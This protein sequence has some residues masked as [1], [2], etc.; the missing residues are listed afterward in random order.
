MKPKRSLLQSPRAL[1]LRDLLALCVVAIAP[2]AVG[3]AGA[4]DGSQRPLGSRSADNVWH[5]AGN[6]G[7]TAD[8]GTRGLPNAY[9]TVRLDRDALQESLARVSKRR[10]NA[11]LPVLTLPM[12]DGSFAR[13]RIDAAPE[14][15]REAVQA[16][17]GRGLD[18]GDARIE[19]TAKGLHAIVLTPRGS[20]Y[21]DPV[22]GVAGDYVTYFAKDAGRPLLDAPDLPLAAV[23]QIE[24]VMGEKASRSPVQRKIDSR[25]LDARQMMQGNEV[26]PGVTYD[27]LPVELEAVDATVERPAEHV[28]PDDGDGAK[29][30]LVDIKAD[31]TPA[32]LARIEEL[33]GEVVNSVRKYRAIRA[34]LPLDTVEVLATL[35]EVQ[36]IRVADRAITNQEVLRPKL[37]S[38]AA[39]T[40]TEKVDTS[41]GDVAHDAAGA[42]AT[43]GVDGTGIGIGV[44]SDGIGTLA[45][46]QA[47]GDLPDSVVILA[48]HAG[49]DGDREGTAM[50]EIVHDLAPGAHLYFA[51]AL[52]G[53]AQFAAN[54]EALCEAG[55]DIIVDDIFYVSEAAFQDD[56]VARG[57]NAAVEA[58]CFY[59]SS[60][61]NGGNLNDGTAGVWEGDFADAGGDLNINGESV[62]DLH[63]F[64]EGVSTNPI[65]DAADFYL[66]KWAD[67]LGASAN[68][69]DLYLV[70]ESLIGLVG[71][72]TDIQDGEHDPL[73]GL[74]GSG[75]SGSDEDVGRHLVVVRHAGEG[76][77]LRLNALRGQLEHATAGQTVGH[78]AGEN[79]IGVAAVDARSAGGDD[80]V[81]DGTESVETFS[82]DGPRRI[83][84]QPDGTPITPED[85]S[86]TGGEVLDKPDIAAADGVSTSTPGFGTFHGTSAAAPHAAAIAALMVEAAGGRNQID[87]PTLRDALAEAALDIEAEG[88]DRDSGAGIPL[89]PAAVS[90]VESDQEHRA[91]NSTLQDQTLNV[92]ADDLELDLSTLFD[93]PD[94]D[95]L[96]YTVLSGIEGI[97]VVTLSGS[98]LTID[99]LAPGTVTVAIRATDAGGLSVV[100]TISVTVERDYGATD[101]DTDDDGLIEI[102]TLEQ[103]NA[104]RYDLDGNGE[105]EV[106]ADW[107][108]YFEA[109]DDAQEEMGCAGGCAGFELMADLDFDEPGSYASGAVDRGWSRAELGAGWE[110]IGIRVNRSSPEGAFVATFD[111]N[112][113]T[114]ANL[115]INRPERDHVGMFGYANNGPVMNVGLTDVNITGNNRVGGLVG[116]LDNWLVGNSGERGIRAS[117]ATGRVSGR[118][119]VGGLIGS[120]SVSIRHCYAAVPVSGD[121]SVGG[122][123]GR[124][125]SDVVHSSFAT[126]A[127]SGK[128]GVG[129]LVGVSWDPIVA[130]YATGAVSGEGSRTSFYC[131]EEGGV[132][133]LLGHACGSWVVASY[134]TGRVS[135]ARAAGGL[136][137]SK[138]GGPT[139]RSSY[140]DIET[141]GLVVGVGDDDANDNG[142][143][144]GGETR[145][146]GVGGMTTAALQRPKGYE[147]IYGEWQGTLDDLPPHDD[148]HFGTSLQYPALKADRNGDGVATW[149]EFGTQVRDR[150]ELTI[151][152]AGGQASLSWTAVT[153]DHWT[154]PLDLTYAVYRDDAVIA[155]GVAADSYT[156]T[157]PGEGAESTV[158]Q[159]VAMVD[160]GEASRSNLVT[161]RNRPPAPPL[162]S[163]QPAR[164]GASFSYTFGGASDPDGDAVTHRATGLPG[165]LT[166]TASTRTFSGSPEAGDVGAT[167][168]TV[169]ATDDGTPV[170]SSTAT[171][172]LTVIALNA[173]NRAP[174]PVGSLDAVSLSTGATSTV[175]VGRA[176]E[177][178]D[179]DVLG[180]QA[181]TS[182]GDVTAAHISADAV[183]LTGIGV[184]EAT[185]TV[186]ATDGALTA[187]QSFAV[188]VVNAEPQAVASLADRGLLI[189]DDPVVLA[190]SEA[191]Y[192]ADSDPLTY[193]ASTSDE[194]VA[195]ASVS[196]AT[197]TLTPIAV[198]SATVTVTATDAGGSNSTATQTFEVTIR[199]DYDID[200]DGL[201]EI[202][203]LGQLDAV[204]FDRDGDGVVDP[205]IGYFTTDPL[206]H[207]VA[208]YRTAYPDA[209]A[210]MGCESVNSCTGYELVADLDF[211]TN[212]SG[213]AD[214]GDTFWNDGRGWKPIG[215]P[216]VLLRIGAYFNS[217]PYAATFD[218]N[219]HVI[220]NLFIDRPDEWFIGL[221]GF[222]H[223][224]DLNRAVIRN[225]G[226][227]DVDVTGWRVTG[228]LVGR[229]SSL[230]EAS[231]ATGRAEAV[232]STSEKRSAAG[233]LV[234]QNGWSAGSR[235]VIR[236]SFAAVAV[237]ADASAVG[238]LVGFNGRLSQVHASFAT[239]SVESNNRSGG[240]VGINDGEVSTSYATGRSTVEFGR[241]G[242]LTA[243]NQGVII[244]SFATGRPT[245]TLPDGETRFKP[246]RLGG[247]AGYST[248]EIVGSYWDTRTSGWRVG[249][250]GDDWPDRNGRVDGN[251]TATPGVLGKT[252]AALQAPE[253]YHGIYGNWNA[254]DSDSWHFGS[255]TQYP[256]L[257]ADIDGDG[258]ATW[259]EFGYQLR[260]TPRLTAAI[261]DGKAELVWSMIDTSHWDPAPPV[262]YAVIRDGEL[263]ATGLEGS[264][265]TDASPGVDYQVAALINGGEASR[266]GISVVVAHCY[267][268]TTWRPGEKCRIAPTS[269]VFEINE[270]GAA[271]VG[272]VC[273][274][275]DSFSVHVETGHIIIRVVAER[276][277]D[278]TWTLQELTPEGPMNQAPIAL[279]ML[280]PVTLTPEDGPVTVD[281]EP[282]FEDPDGD[283]LTYAAMTSRGGV[284]TVSMTRSRLTV[285]P[286]GEGRATVTVTARD[287]GGLFAIQAVAVTVESAD[288]FRWVRGWRLKVLI[289][290]AESSAGDAGETSDPGE[291]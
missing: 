68:D 121:R 285:T 66:L 267:E 3:Q 149:Q 182:D 57:V 197:V 96:T 251:E 192:D 136:V 206:P 194:D 279:G 291:P 233:G 137:G 91:P 10:H 74:L 207:E 180:Y 274:T 94:G 129:G 49:E 4:D 37:V 19:W 79:A 52:G 135:A 45:E 147:G 260:D 154:P 202:A 169:T 268:D 109:F 21:V 29:R 270:D 54:I 144:D 108:L 31:V 24:S 211:D 216:S 283:A 105:T 220:S 289:D 86:S 165:W 167:E 100:R 168:I 116:E 238:G 118:D 106:P 212:G 53:A 152:T 250:G 22:P 195:T 70:D 87:L 77:Y 98:I 89:A 25:L 282:F 73:E 178:A 155:T 95:A 123:I 113:H 127:V 171:F 47:S 276:S 32:V 223:V 253:D 143:L 128:T 103:L 173:D 221:F 117:H 161:V 198:G 184:G 229:N 151:V 166:F 140:W 61:G 13:F 200:D 5:F 102:A 265:Y 263:L 115:F 157:P 188:T 247:L 6:S 150:P 190:A 185:V 81:F 101:Y 170:L 234:G 51:T 80:G 23:R 83:F 133:G 255:S 214:E 186:T 235:G 65:T 41:E 164:A 252:T 42:R 230:I 193:G 162:V 286:L 43:L 92:Y 271:C 248:G 191:F 9:M 213:D 239:G 111:G 287:P 227:T 60:A 75:L 84:F 201:I 28:R 148:W 280:E 264:S 50:L 254:D 243:Q 1:R 189:P 245:P 224:D 284:A 30:V 139:I 20:V 97:A 2:V 266:S 114:I 58:G 125:D 278:G 46:R 141:S 222:I 275:D 18:T 88:V 179:G 219:G 38:D 288:D 196:G 15:S 210:N 16:Y 48:G 225:V 71:A 159:V 142:T 232:A 231:Y 126:G 172:T 181:A 290:N 269:F 27:R 199:R 76:R 104:L 257:R 85:F 39:T 281:V 183:V 175:P 34:W 93:D 160:G 131:G 209:A 14:P 67:P 262:R 273:S 112:R 204:H 56:V 258:E 205:E 240:L 59:F 40:G 145:T 44:L 107:E 7:V 256:V 176:F 90:V 187:E 246:V 99:P 153:G 217:E 72:S 122:L 228:S 249:V 208:A 132:G 236:N 241:A 215:Q 63:A 134:A 69:Y 36:R 55:A 12:P 130:S 138:S 261:E 218:G 203:K 174:V 163:S 17:R 272:S 11:P 110:P 177:D 120:S 35:D 244:N 277:A 146:P 226:L 124:Q 237:S 62:G 242:G 33:G 119:A 82:A 158:Y 8:V 26:A 156:D 259:R 78:S 64:A